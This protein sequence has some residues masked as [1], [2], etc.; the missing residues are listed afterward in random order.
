MTDQQ[1]IEK[2]VRLFRNIDSDELTPIETE[3][4]E[5]LTKNGKNPFENELTPK[6]RRQGWVDDCNGHSLEDYPLTAF[7]GRFPDEDKMFHWHI[8]DA[9]N[10]IHP[11]TDK[12]AE[13]KADSKRDTI[14]WAYEVFQRKLLQKI[15]TR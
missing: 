9:M 10:P 2:I 12:I 13:G 5:I 14:A 4:H 15:A 11:D 1:I 3:I 8:R 7:V 6:E